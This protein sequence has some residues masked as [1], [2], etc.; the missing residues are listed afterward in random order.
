MWFEKFV[1]LNI[2]CLHL[3]IWFCIAFFKIHK[4]DHSVL[5]IH[6]IYLPLRNLGGLST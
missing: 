1:S 3:E 5:I 4:W 6:L 2:V